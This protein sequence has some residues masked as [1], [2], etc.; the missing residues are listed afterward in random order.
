MSL[1]ASHPASAPDRAAGLCLAC[2]KR[3]IVLMGLHVGLIRQQGRTSDNLDMVVAFLQ[4]APNRQS[5]PLI[6]TILLIE[7]KDQ[8]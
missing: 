7:A 3:Y 5:E 1:T 6:A 2:V 4:K 8:M